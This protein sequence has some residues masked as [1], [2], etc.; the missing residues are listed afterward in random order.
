MTTLEPQAIVGEGWIARHYRPEDKP[1]LL[2]LSQFHY[3]TRDQA[4]EAYIDWYSGESPAGR[5][6]V[7]VGEDT[8][9]RE[10]IGFCFFM[11]VIAKVGNEYGTARMGGNAVVHPDY[12]RR[13][14]FSSFHKVAGEE[15][16]TSWFSY[17]FPKPRAL[18]AHQKGGRRKVAD[19]PL[20]VRPIDMR[21]LARDRLRNPLLRG[22]ARAGWWLAGRTLWRQPRPNPQGI[23]VRHEEGFDAS[24]DRFWDRV[25]D[26]YEI[27]IKRDSAFLN[28][29]FSGLDFRAYRLLTAR[30]NGELVGYL[31]LRCTQI[32]GVRTGLIMDL[33][34]EPGAR[35]DRAGLLL[36]AAAT[37]HFSTNGMAL[38]GC[39][40]LPHTQEYRI[41]VRGGYINA[42]GRFTPQR[43]ML[44]S[45]SFSERTPAEYLTR[46]ERWFISMANH[47][48]V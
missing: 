45:Q 17:G 48:A 24:F 13:G 11:P 22:A 20:L 14:I 7:I 2:K 19:L 26:K 9:S 43:F 18:V 6:T 31:V 32:E 33:L 44:L 46:A 42:P 12:R 3:G 1:G 27:I 16:A 34:V 15:L 35:G 36:L 29:R 30:V 39:L 5:A 4:H 23:V 21:Q 28:W 10:I 40:L 47:D 38:S 41:V 37:Q 25:A 8:H